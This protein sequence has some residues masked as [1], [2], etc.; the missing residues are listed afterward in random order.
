M[1][2]AFSVTPALRRLLK[3]HNWH[4]SISVDCFLIY[5]RQKCFS[6]IQ[7]RFTVCAC[8][9]IQTCMYDFVFM[10][11]CATVGLCIYACVTVG[12][13]IHACVTV[14]LCNMHVWLSV[15]VCMCE[16]RFTWLYVWLSWLYVRMS[17]YMFVCLNASLR[18]CANAYISSCTGRRCECVCVCV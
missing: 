1:A 7:D 10:I 6:R 12:L 13:R 15:C 8:I 14:G 4:V 17:V 18:V 2:W 5:T 9:G 3:P 16:C 11:I